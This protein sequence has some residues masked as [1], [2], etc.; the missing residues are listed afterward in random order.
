[1]SIDISNGSSSTELTSS[2]FTNG[3]S[4]IFNNDATYTTYD[5]YSRFTN[6]VFIDGSIDKETFINSCNYNTFPIVYYSHSNSNKLYEFLIS[7]FTN[8]NRIAFV[9]HGFDIKTESSKVL[10][11]NGE[12][13]FTDEDLDINA[14][15]Y[16]INHMFITNLINKLSVQNADFLACNLLQFQEWKTYFDI[17]EKNSNVVVGASDDK[18]GNIKYGGDW[19]LE[20]TLEDVKNI[21][22]NENIENM[23]FT[24]LSIA[25]GAWTYT[26]NTY[27]FSNYYGFDID[28]LVSNLN[29][30]NYPTWVE[31]KTNLTQTVRNTH[32]TI[33]QPLE[34][35]TIGS[36]T[37]PVIQYGYNACAH[38][39]A[40][41]NSFYVSNK[42]L[43]FAHEAFVYSYYV[44]IVFPSDANSS[45][46]GIG[47]RVFGS[48]R[49]LINVVIPS[50]VRIIAPLAFL[51]MPNL[52]SVTFQNGFGEDYYYYNIPLLMFYDLPKLTTINVANWDNIRTIG[53]GTN[54]WNDNREQ[55]YYNAGFTKFRIPRSCNF[56]V[57]GEFLN[58]PNMKNFY[59]PKEVGVIQTTNGSLT[60][61]INT[62]VFAGGETKN[63]ATMSGNYTNTV[64][65]TVVFEPRTTNIELT[66]NF[67][68]HNLQKTYYVG[69][70]TTATNYNIY[71]YTTTAKNIQTVVNALI[72]SN[73][74]TGWTTNILLSELVN[75]GYTNRDIILSGQYDSTQLSNTLPNGFTAQELLNSSITYEELITA[76][77][78]STDLAT[79]GFTAVQLAAIG[80][81]LEQLKLGF[82]LEEIYDTMLY[83]LGELANA[84]FTPDELAVIRDTLISNICF[85]GNTPVKTDQGI[86][87]IDKLD[88]KIHTIQNKTI[89]AITKTITRDK[90]L[91]CIKKHAFGE[92]FP[93]KKTIISNHHKLLYKGHMVQA[94]DLVGKVKDVS[95]IDY[96]G[97]ILYNVLLETHE[98]MIVNNLIVETLNPNNA[99]AK[100]HL[101]FV[102]SDKTRIRRLTRLSNQYVIKNT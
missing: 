98:K 28:E 84:G 10:F 5:D 92:N 51:S 68:N 35:V 67:L 46:I 58:M 55:V 71:K 99:I 57:S 70:Y 85:P 65:D 18:T 73:N 88:P 29:L 91:V 86:I 44:N 72:T 90:Y 21:Y 87:K 49:V 47:H 24:L 31:V 64:V 48:N 93:N 40:A 102:G 41:N 6:I 39:Y 17:L 1:M 61:N 97:E 25:I 95:F 8:I 22:F 54:Y 69:K 15:S 66:D 96:N 34:D 74:Y 100:I 75:V 79:A 77:Y 78:D 76:G 56:I 83:T 2:D 36:N 101:L 94:M 43:F 53:R 9:F 13:L 38:F 19:V 81:T 26:E 50:S 30:P 80:T 16:S 4:N 52:E 11:M 42:I 63:L 45:I 59:I 12:Y 37:Y 32:T 23:N 3:E 89:L 20:N 62:G 60:V 14:T 27:T 82:T 7:N 33:S